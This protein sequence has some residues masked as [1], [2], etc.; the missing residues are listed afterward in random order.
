MRQSKLI[1][2]IFIVVIL[3]AS[4]Q[5]SYAQ[6]NEINFNAYRGLF[7]FYGN[8][9]AS[10]TWINYNPYTSPDWYTSNVYGRKSK[11]SYA[12]EIQ[13]Q[14]VTKRKNIIGS[15]LGFE[16]LTSKVTIDTLT[17]NGFLYWKYPASGKTTL[18]N[19]FIT[20]NPFVGHRYSYHK[21]TFDVLAG[22]DLAFC[23]KSKEAGKASTN[24]KDFVMA[25]NDKTKPF[26]DF[27][28]RVQI[29]MKI[30]KVGFLAGYSFGLTN[31][32]AE[33]NLKAWTRFL[34]LGLSYQ[35][36]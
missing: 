1:K 3:F 4:I 24:N 35:L 21:A 34:R 10:N 28:P 11:F 9:S 25:E 6:K 30:N 2:I 31:Y 36:K 22:C 23:L 12:F 19:T 29:K 16:A 14:H 27:R 26:I 20:L 7:S 17:E 32:Q 15:G 33:N 18:R 8:G 5:F 13:G